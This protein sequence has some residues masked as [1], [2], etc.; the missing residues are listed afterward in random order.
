MSELE[1]SD[2]KDLASKAQAVAKV[3][4]EYG[5]PPEKL[6]SLVELAAATERLAVAAEREAIA[7]MVENIEPMAQRDGK[8]AEYADATKAICCTIAALIRGRK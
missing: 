6:T 8:G 1:T 5:I 2:A 4:E 3:A 7:V